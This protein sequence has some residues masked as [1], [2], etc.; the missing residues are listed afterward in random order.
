ML[1]LTNVQVSSGRIISDASDFDKSKNRGIRTHNWFSKI[2]ADLFGSGTISVY[3][4]DKKYYV[5][6]K[7]CYKLID[8]PKYTFFKNK[9]LVIG[10][11]QSIFD[12][13]HSGKTL[14]QGASVGFNNRYAMQMQQFQ[15][16]VLDNKDNLGTMAYGEA[17]GTIKFFQHIIH[18]D[19][20]TDI[21]TQQGGYLYQFHEAPELPLGLT[22][23]YQPTKNESEK[24]LTS[25]FCQFITALDQLKTDQQKIRF[26]KELDGYCIE[27]KTSNA[28]VYAASIAS[29][30]VE[31]EPFHVILQRYR[32]EAHEA[33]KGQNLTI[34]LLA[35][36]I[37]NKHDGEKCLSDVNLC[38]DGIINLESAKA[39]LEIT[40]FDL[41]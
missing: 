41:L 36:Y 18:R 26:C 25:L 4:D 38:K 15:D 40:D 23:H 34:D 16:W 14:T 20:I 27:A 12:E 39:F 17:M 9:T 37:N 6:K 33:L 11:I 2:L 35:E 28:F 7:S 1:R 5:N 32:D 19:G 3:I 21:L 10:Q 31:L 29:N 22:F 24:A 8:N 30:E 13:M